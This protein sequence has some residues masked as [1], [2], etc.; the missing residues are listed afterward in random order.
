MSRHEHSFKHK[1]EI[2]D[3][4]LFEGELYY[5]TALSYSGYTDGDSSYDES[6]NYYDIT[7]T[8]DSEVEIGYVF[9]DDLKLHKAK[10]PLVTQEDAEEAF[11]AFYH[12]TPTVND[13]LDMYNDYKALYEAFGEEEYKYEMDCALKQLAEVTA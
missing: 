10:T 9:E 3:M 11:K 5:V 4:V 7:L 12:R 2:G 8:S 1:F 6:E 13:L